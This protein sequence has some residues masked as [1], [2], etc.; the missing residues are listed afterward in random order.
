M[1]DQLAKQAAKDS[2]PPLVQDGEGDIGG[3]GA[4]C[5]TCHGNGRKG[6]CLTCGEN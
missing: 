2:T 5:P 4:D 6:G 3:H 1:A